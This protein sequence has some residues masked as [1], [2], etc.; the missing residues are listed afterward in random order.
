MKSTLF[1]ALLLI[2][3][4][5][6]G[7][8][9]PKKGNLGVKLASAPENSYQA[10]F[11]IAEVME[12]TTAESLGLQPNDLLI[13]INDVIFDDGKKIP[14]VIGK[15]IAGEPVTAKVL[16]KGQLME[17]RGVVKAPPPFKQP[18]H[19]L[20]LLEVPFREGF[21]RAYLTHPKG[22]G[23]FPTIY[24]IQ[25]YPCQSINTQL[26]H[27]TAQLTSGL[28]DLGYAVF[29]IEKPGIGEFV[30]LSPCMEYSFD[31]E[32]ENFK[33]GLSFLRSLEQVDTSNIVL[34]GHSLGGNV[35]PLIAQES[36]L[37]GVITFGTLIKSWEDYLLDMAY[38][39]QTQSQ[40]A[41]EVVQDISI[42]K[43]AN[44]KLYV[45]DLPHTTLSQKEKQLLSNWHDYKEDGTI[46]N[47][48]I[49][50]WKS[51]SEYN[52]FEQ[53]SKVNVPVLSLY[54]ESDAHAISSLDAELI[55]QTVNQ[56]QGE[57]ATFMLVEE[58]NHLF[59][60]VPT[61]MQELE[62]I[63]SGLSGQ[64]AYTK[65]NPKLPVL[66][67]TWIQGEKTK[68][69]QRK[70]DSLNTHFPQSETKMSSMDVVAADLNQDGQ[71]DL[72]IATEFGPNKVFLYEEGKWNNRTLPQLGTYTPP[73]LGEDSE[74]IA[75]A[76]FDRDGDLDLFFVS[77]DTK[78][79]E[80]LYNDGKAT[81]TLPDIQIPKKGQAN[82]VLVFDFNQDKWPD[83]LI[84]I[85]GQ[86]ELYINQ[87]GKG[88]K[89]STSAFW[90]V[91]EDH[92]QDLILVDIDQDGD[93]DILE[94]I[95]S[96]GNNAYLNESGTFKEA[97]DLLPLPDGIET[98]KIVASDF[99]QDGDA[100]LLFCNVGWQAGKDPQNQLLLNDGNGTFTNVTEWLPED[101]STTLD[102]VFTD[103]NN[104][105]TTDLVTTNF[106]NDTKVKVF[107][108]KKEDSTFSFTEH[109]D[110]LP[111][112]NFY[113][114]TSV[115]AFEVDGAEFLYFANF[116]SGDHLMREK[117]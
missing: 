1:F 13:E 27:P 60:S 36:S 14:A 110:V 52:Y 80:L 86:N 61:R 12:Q 16:R 111:K 20:E 104:D 96:G 42:L 21:V 15:F 105:G 56:H 73:Y 2:A 89:E 109:P 95:E 83:I 48:Q 115:L 108:G 24:Y 116:K 3:I 99:D 23:P 75:V 98:R 117:G 58:T 38:Y 19:E 22:E 88:F 85:R 28:V 70:F 107:L 91:N 94:G 114:G 7:Q 65:F 33:N 77:E 103:L 18:H 76:D 29:R 37:A 41:L 78:N 50:F 32:V 44:H 74:D 49:D 46:F 43:S 79:H 57:M 54:G 11:S 112:I 5:L 25:G 92:T 26:Q 39:S 59:A 101:S 100:D 97:S 93:L 81:F 106:V 45:E 67:D 84:G 64:I 10:I 6:N 53:W 51:F 40:N 71:N 35:A 17:L 82:A 4:S 31:D 55:V 8:H 69:S 62:Y 102:A 30:D 113:G 34:F 47:R 66:I 72:V 90:P 68:K 63:N 87:K 9:I